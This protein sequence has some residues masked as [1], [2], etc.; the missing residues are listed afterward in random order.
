MGFIIQVLKSQK[1]NS[2][3]KLMNRNSPHIRDHLI[4]LNAHVPLLSFIE[5]EMLYLLFIALCCKRFPGSFR[6]LLAGVI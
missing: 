1:A 6:A 3:F 2:C 5:E 4:L